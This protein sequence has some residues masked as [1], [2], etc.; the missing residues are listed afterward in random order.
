MV[1]AYARYLGLSPEEITKQFLSEYHDFENRE[2]R[3]NSTSQISES[4]TNSGHFEA[5]PVPSSY[6]S[7]NSDGQG[8]RSMWDRPI[9]KSEL[10]RGYDSRSVAAQRVAN[11]ASR[12]RAQSGSDKSRARRGGDSYTSRQS[13]PKRIFG[14]IFNSPIV[15]IA[16]LVAIL[17]ALLVVWA[18]AANSCKRQGSENE[19]TNHVT[20]TVVTDEPTE[21]DATEPLVP[22]QEEEGNPNAGAFELA[23]E[24]ASGTAP[25]T[26]VTVDGEKIYAQALS[27]GQAWQVTDACSVVTAQPNNVS[28]TRNGEAVS[29]EMDGNG[30]GSVELAVEKEPEGEQE[31]SSDG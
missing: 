10:N 9:P 13:L 29:F 16:V 1:S 6:A 22:V 2:A 28:V 15:L 4:V 3:Q 20:A 7:K 5:N 31:G 18:L 26:E 14:T 12:R 17:V 25:W 11:A 8:V 19:P 21:S 23:L 24:P 27:E 30:F